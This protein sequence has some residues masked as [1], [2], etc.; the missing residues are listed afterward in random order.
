MENQVTSF[1][2]ITHCTMIT[3]DM[4]VHKAI[5]QGIDKKME[6]NKKVFIFGKEVSQLQG[7]Y[8]VTKGLFQKYSSKQIIDTDTYITKKGFTGSSICVMWNILC[9]IVDFMT[10]NFSI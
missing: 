4:I 7:A 3:I 5:H 8:E 1:F 9:S 6:C 10:W 2:Y